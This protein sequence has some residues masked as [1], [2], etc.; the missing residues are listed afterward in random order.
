MKTFPFLL[1]FV[2]ALVTAALFWVAHRFAGLP[3]VSDFAVNALS[4]V[5]GIGVIDRLL[6]RHEER[7]WSGAG[8]LIDKELARLAT[9]GLLEINNASQAAGIT[10]SD[11]R[12]SAAPDRSIYAWA[13]IE[14][15]PRVAAAV[16]AAAAKTRKEIMVRVGAIDARVDRIT[17][18]CGPRLLPEDLESLLELSRLS[19]QA[20]FPFR[21]APELGEA[22]PPAEKQKALD[23]L[24]R[25]MDPAGAIA[26][27]ADELRRLGTRKQTIALRAR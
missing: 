8:T 9:D 26:R 5:V 27:L 21:A 15:R 22:N 14:L 20:L 25:S 16:T 10:F 1:V 11:Y 19:A 18:M 3:Y 17:M 6:A 23:E 4:L 7:Q 2:L 24:W 12:V 13:E